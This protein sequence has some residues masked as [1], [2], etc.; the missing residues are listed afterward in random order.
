MHQG[1]PTTFGTSK[2]PQLMKPFL[3]MSHNVHNSSVNV[4]QE[5]LRKLKEVFPKTS[6]VKLAAL[7]KEEDGDLEAIVSRVIAAEKEQVADT[8]EN[9]TRKETIVDMEQGEEKA[10]ISKVTV[11]AEVLKSI[12]QNVKEFETAAN[13]TKGAS[14]K[15]LSFHKPET[16]TV[17]IK[18]APQDPRSLAL[19]SYMC[20]ERMRV[21]CNVC[22]KTLDNDNFNF[23]PHCGYLLRKNYRRL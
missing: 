17:S 7:I 21:Y 23:C 10:M 11:D 15:V 22:A 2:E 9:P 6:E 20:G 8:A 12:L 16:S 19:S 3:K 1:S 18:N 13:D 5:Q 14:G 4:F